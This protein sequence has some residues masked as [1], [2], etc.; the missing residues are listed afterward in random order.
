MMQPGRNDPCPCGSGKKYK[1]CC[2]TTSRAPLSPDVA[3]ANAV[4]D[5]DNRLTE[6]ILRF[7]RMKLGRD[8]LQSA[9][10]AYTGADGTLDDAE[11]QLG[12]PWSIY[13]FP[14]GERNVTLAHIFR[15]ESAG[16]LPPDLREV[17]DAH[18]RAWLSVWEVRR[19]EPGVGAS[20]TDL[21]TGEERFVHEVSGSR[22][23]NARDALLGWV[24]DSGAISIFGGIHPQPLE[25]RDAD[26]VVRE[27][28]RLCRVRTRPVKP[29]RLR[30]P[31]VQL[32]LIDSW[33]DH[34]ELRRTRPPPRFT[35]TDGDPLVLTTDHFDVLATD[36]ST[37][38]SRLTTLSGAGEPEAGERG[39]DEKVITITKAGNARMKSWDNTIIG[40]VVVSGN[41]MRAESNSTRRADAL[42]A[43]LTSHLGELVRHR[44][45]DEVSQS[46]LLRR[47]YEEPRHS[48]TET[49]PSNS[50]GA[51]GILKEFKERH[52][53]AWLDEEIPALGGMTP[54]A[55]AKS[56]RSMK[57]LEIL[58]REL[59]NHEARLPENER[60]DVE[61]LRTELGMP[62]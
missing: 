38:P 7:S 16:R 8:W 21:L 54:R 13:G 57:S 62:M 5:A 29:E 31:F 49:L 50:R 40:R 33:R 19:V 20:L 59:E 46:E 27:I 60:F 11:M 4:K 35:N 55:A 48:D 30:E 15:E 12:V 34:A 58:L 36:S 41:R 56:P 37:L 43:S 9:L 17:L 42:R 18:L 10:D 44:L 25:P 22:T 3:R 2:E 61:R 45:R 24:V 39:G 1:K 23:L 14:F 52:M 51:A 47:A 6:R 28:R 32:A 26:L 53:L